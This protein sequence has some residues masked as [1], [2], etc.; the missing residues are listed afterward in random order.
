M[1]K[2]GISDEGFERM[3]KKA[4]EEPKI[5]VSVTSSTLSDGSEVFEVDLYIGEQGGVMFDMVDEGWA[6]QL[7]QELKPLLESMVAQGGIVGAEVIKG[8]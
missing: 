2:R 8:E 4:Q 5:R 1:W 7:V 3:S 6:N